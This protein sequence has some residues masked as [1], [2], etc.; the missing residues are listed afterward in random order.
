[1]GLE[2]LDVHRVNID[3]IDIPRWAK[4]IREIKIREL[5]ELIEQEE[6]EYQGIYESSAIARHNKRI[7]ISELKEKLNLIVD[8]NGI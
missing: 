7:R 1:M 3:N 2:N 8:K 4:Q 5:R 6:K